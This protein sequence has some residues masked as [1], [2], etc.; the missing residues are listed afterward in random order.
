MTSTTAPGRDR[1][2]VEEVVAV[3][4]PVQLCRIGSLLFLVIQPYKQKQQEKEEEEEE[5][6]E[7]SKSDTAPEPKRRNSLPPTPYRLTQGDRVAELDLEAANEF[8]R[9]FFEAAEEDLMKHLA[10]LGLAL[11][12]GDSSSTIVLYSKGVVMTRE[13]VHNVL[14]DVDLLLQQPGVFDFQRILERVVAACAAEL[15]ER[16]G[17]FAGASDLGAQLRQVKLVPN[18]VSGEEYMVKYETSFCTNMSA[19]E[20]SYPNPYTLT[21]AHMEVLSRRYGEETRG[22]FM[23]CFFLHCFSVPCHEMLHCVQ[24]VLGQEDKDLLSWSA[25]HDASF[26]SLSL[27]WAISERDDMR[28]LFVPGFREEIMVETLRWSAR[29]LVHWDDVAMREYKK[30]R[31]S[32]GMQA[33]CKSICDDSMTI[34]Q[35]KGV[36]AIERMCSDQAELQAQLE[37]LFRDRL[38]DVYQYADRKPPKMTNKFIIAGGGS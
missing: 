35:F 20:I 19:R 2:E 5:A 24:H 17:S 1:R 3:I 29:V 32:F 22:S 6:K 28:D 9:T 18:K 34:G 27:L 21:D 30:W 10:M 25:E 13:Q 26:A 16:C 23:R 14:L 11:G 37:F 36:L 31:D 12:R 4:D 8:E 38:G 15:S 33:P 7:E